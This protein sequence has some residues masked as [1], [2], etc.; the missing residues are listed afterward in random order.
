MDQ[1]MVNVGQGV[2]YNGDEVVLFGQQGT[3]QIT[4]EEVARA[5]GL[6]PYEILVTLNQRIP[7]VFVGN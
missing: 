5:S 2:A 7:R 4:V 1:L 6:S 3:E